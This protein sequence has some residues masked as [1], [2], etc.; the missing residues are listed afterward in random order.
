M[1]VQ[2]HFLISGAVYKKQLSHNLDLPLADTVSVKQVYIH[3]S[4]VLVSR[5]LRIVFTGAFIYSQLFI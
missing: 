4:G 1:P 5:N 3:F 2:I